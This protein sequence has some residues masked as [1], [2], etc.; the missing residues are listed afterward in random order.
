MIEPYESIIRVVAAGYC[1][2]SRG[3]HG[4]WTRKIIPFVSHKHIFLLLLALQYTCLVGFSW[5]AVPFII[6]MTL[7]TW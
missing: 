3:G 1:D 6:W 7:R 5:W 2:F 4:Q